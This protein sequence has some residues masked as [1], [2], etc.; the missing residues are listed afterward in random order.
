MFI[1]LC[2]QLYIDSSS[3]QWDTT[4]DERPLQN[5][6]RKKKATR[7]DAGCEARIGPGGPVGRTG[8]GEPRAQYIG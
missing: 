8:P 1:N 6:F 7:N 3:V 5:R 2:I 4:V